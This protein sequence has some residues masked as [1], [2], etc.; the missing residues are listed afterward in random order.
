[1]LNARENYQ[2]IDNFELYRS[3][4]T[5][6]ELGFISALR[7]AA[8]LKARALKEV[9]NIA[10][11]I[12]VEKGP[13]APGGANHKQQRRLSKALK[14]VESNGSSFSD[15]LPLE[16]DN[17]LG[18]CSQELLAR[19]TELLKRTRK[20]THFFNIL[21]CF[22]LYYAFK[23]V[24]I[25][26]LE[27]AIVICICLWCFRCFALEGCLCLHQPIGAGKNKFLL[28]IGILFF[29][30]DILVFDIQQCCAGDAEDEKQACGWNH[31]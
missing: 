14:E 1:M 22:I 31:H 7:G 11:V 25:F 3:T 12:P 10:A 15:D 21:F 4:K 28:N 18:L 20:G 5:N 23:N 29:W 26:S 16:E 8:T 13:V 27:V 19:G 2:H 9:W 30:F 6:R 24:E 17:F